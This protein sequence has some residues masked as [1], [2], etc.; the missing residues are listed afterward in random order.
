MSGGQAT[1]SA[2]S[3]WLDRLEN[4]RT[5]EKNLSTKIRSGNVANLGTSV[6]ALQQSVS[7]LRREFDSMTSGSTT[8]AVATPQELRRREDLL[9]DL[10]TQTRSLLAA[11]NNRAQGTKGLV[12]IFSPINS[13]TIDDDADTW[14]R[15]STLESGAQMLRVQNQIMLDQDDQLSLIGQGVSNLK[16]YS[17]SV[18]NETDLHV[19]L[20]DDI[21]VDVDRATTG[22]E[23]EG[24]RAQILAKKSSNFRL[25]LAIVVLTA[26]LVFEL[27][28]GGS[29]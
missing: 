11:Y 28:I 17:L 18:K 22:L 13:C 4:A 29:K 21:N 1:A 15:S 9:R 26:I 27:I 3:A 25:Y 7:R 8:N 20:L 5:S 6:F 16:Q 2:W 19:R 14:N 23:A 12:K 10:E 24:D